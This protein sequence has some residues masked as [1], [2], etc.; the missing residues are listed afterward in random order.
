[1]NW[2]YPER[3]KVLLFGGDLLM[4]AATAVIAGTFHPVSSSASTHPAGRIVLFVLVFPACFYICDLYDLRPIEGARTFVRL[5]AAF[6]LSTCII[7]VFLLFFQWPGFSRIGM[8]I[9][10]IL[11]FTANLSWRTIYKLNRS[12]FARRRGVLLIGR[13]RDAA[14]LQSMMESASCP[15]EFTGLLRTSAGREP[16]VLSSVVEPLVAVATAAGGSYQVVGTTRVE[17]IASSSHAEQFRENP[18]TRGFTFHDYGIADPQKLE[19]LALNCG[20]DTIVVNPDFST[21]EL[22]ESLM[23]LR[24]QGIRISTL[25]DFCSQILEK[26]PL[27]TLNDSWF[28]FASGFHLLHKRIFRKVKRL[29]DILLACVGLIITL[30]ISVLAAVVIKIESPG[31]VLFRQWRVGRREQPFLLFKFRSMRLDAESDGQARWATAQDP[32]VTFIGR[33]LRKLHIDE[34]PQMINVLLG[35]MSFVGPRPER[36]VFVEQFKRQVPFYHLRHYLPP[37]ITGW[38]Q[39][40]YPY[41]DCMEDARNKL[42]YDLYYVR[43]ASLTLDLRILLRTARVILFRTG[44]R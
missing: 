40:N 19:Q 1:V 32:R 25:P 34:I 27:E 41:G 28:S 10:A 15:C 38:A 4:A 17:E 30:P 26:L 31:P 3:G 7:G 43:N 12:R 33:I 44:S 22:A 11:F 36:P 5:L 6:V 18:E 37:G 21:V 20:V 29:M 39:V 13:E 8:G 42:Q 16:I 2:G 35:Q 9:A 14:A 23:R 24:F